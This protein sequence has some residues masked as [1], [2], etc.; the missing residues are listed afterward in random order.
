[1]A[2]SSLGGGTRMITVADGPATTDLSD[3]GCDQQRRAGQGGERTLTLSGANT[4]TGTTTWARALLQIQNSAA[5][6]TAA[7][8]TTV[9]SDATL[10]VSNGLLVA[11]EP[12]TIN[13]MGVGGNRGPVL[14]RWVQHLGR[15]DSPRLPT[16]PWPTRPRDG[17]SVGYRQPPGMSSPTTRGTS[18]QVATLLGIISGSGGL[19]DQRHGQVNVVG[20]N[21]YSGTTMGRA[22]RTRRSADGT[23]GDSTVVPS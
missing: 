8:G 12:L 18:N 13:G 15:A 6:G 14:L 17:S 16:R 21:T 20:A 1:V 9:A 22:R 19:P 5:L 4:Y 11:A 3:L 2:S 10:Q 7:G 23:L